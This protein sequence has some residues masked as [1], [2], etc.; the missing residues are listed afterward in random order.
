MK[1][2][3]GYDET[4]A[5][6]EFTPIELG[7]HHMIIKK[8]EETQTATGKDMIIVYYDF[9]KNDKQ[10]DY[11]AN[12]F[13]NDIRPE[14]KWPR[15][16]TAYVVVEDNNGNCTRNFKTFITSFERSN[17]VEAN[18]GAKFSTQFKD[19]K[20]GGVFGEVE[21]EWNG[22]VSMRHELRWFCSDEKADTAAIPAV[23]YLNA[24]A[25]ASTPSGDDSFINVPETD[26]TDLPF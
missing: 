5:S 9:A 23:K 20:I 19:K 4:K 24:T 2:P 6:G 12:E 8:V 18:W 21:N 16:G 17:N 3:T 11:M 25:P 26:A 1:K 7:G 13:R 10:P 14:K 22:K 15:S